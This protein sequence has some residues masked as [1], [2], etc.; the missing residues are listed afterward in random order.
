MA[1][2]ESV[3]EEA[4]ALARRT[5]RALLAIDGAMFLAEAVA[6]WWIRPHLVA[7]TFAPKPVVGS[8]NGDSRA[9]FA[10]LQEVDQ[11]AAIRMRVPRLLLA[12]IHDGFLPPGS[13][14][15]R[16]RR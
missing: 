9:V 14:L 7:L 12:V 10:R 11:R 13:L 8:R 3:L 6:G 2:R 5:L 16:S 1:E 4:A 15:E